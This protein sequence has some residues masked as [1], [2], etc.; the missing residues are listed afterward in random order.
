MT[1]QSDRMLEDIVPTRLLAGEPHHACEVMRLEFRSADAETE[2]AG[3]E[4]AQITPAEDDAVRTVARLT[5]LNQRLE[6]EAEQLRERIEAART[7]N[8]NA[9]TE[10]QAELE[11][12]V[13]VERE[14]VA[15]FCAQFER[16]RARYFAGVEAE[17]V[18]L[19]L[20]IAAR[21]LHREVRLDPLLLAGVVRVALENISDSST[22]VLRVPAA[23]QETWREAFAARKD[24]AVQVAGDDRL[25]N[26]EC[27]L[28]SE[29]GNVEL[30][31]GAQLDEIE[32]GFFD[33][34]EK[35]PA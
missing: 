27:V 20:A 10:W 16:E 15:K 2:Q 9:R 3:M 22:A 7:E 34:L 23:E 4:A 1:S 35:R 28:E 33:L 14:R 5:A 6:S 24:V 26:G 8:M 32:R 31:V 25:R 17:V 29:V 11:Q 13:A 19:A 18:R 30:G 12:S 21:V